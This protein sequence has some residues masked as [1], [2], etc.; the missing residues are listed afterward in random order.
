MIDFSDM[1]FILYKF[2]FFVQDNKSAY[3]LA[4]E[5]NNPDIL[6]VVKI[7][8]SSSSSSRNDPFVQLLSN[9]MSAKSFNPR[10]SIVPAQVYIHILAIV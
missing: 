3:D 4:K 8:T 9:Y 5:G 2:Y 10:P 1:R 6:E 7:P